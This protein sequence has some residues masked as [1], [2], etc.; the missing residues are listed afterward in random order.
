MIN[1]MLD[2]L[3]LVSLKLDIGNF[4]TCFRDHSRVVRF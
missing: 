1:E 2:M 3:L 4:I